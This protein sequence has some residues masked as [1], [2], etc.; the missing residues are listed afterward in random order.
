[1]RNQT[2]TSAYLQT[3]YSLL[4]ACCHQCDKTWRNFA[5]L[6][7]HVT[8]LANFWWFFFGNILNL[9]WRKFYAIGLNFIVL[10]GQTLNSYLAIGHCGCHE[11]FSSSC[12]RK[13]TIH[14]IRRLQPIIAEATIVVFGVDP[15]F[16][17][18]SVDWKLI[19]SPL[20]RCVGQIYVSYLYLQRN[21]A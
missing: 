16:N 3:F 2:A 15:R 4:K 7:K 17:K 9:L 12:I 18:I 21:F 11:P 6:A 10:N 1:M 20:Q 19:F 14:L 8:T 5:T 13:F